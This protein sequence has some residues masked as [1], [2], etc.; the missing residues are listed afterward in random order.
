MAAALEQ[1]TKFV[2]W[3]KD[4]GVD[5]N[6]IAPAQFVNRGMGIVAAKD[7]KVSDYTCLYLQALAWLR[8]IRRVK[9]L[10]SFV[11]SLLTSQERRS[12]SAR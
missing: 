2:I 3:A 9:D 6:G 12:A 1:H 4:N 10:Q 11:A 5:I 7:I 8:I